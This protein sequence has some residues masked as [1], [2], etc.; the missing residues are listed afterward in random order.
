MYTG[1]LSARAAGADVAGTRDFPDH[2]R[3]TATEFAAVLEAAQRLGAE[4]VTTPKDAVRLTPA[5][6]AKV[7]IAGVR[8]VWDDAAQRDAMLDA[9]LDA[10]PVTVTG[11]GTG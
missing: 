3:F 10:M 7:R 5:Q 9:M 2:H 8:L 6:R 4:P 1:P 11:T